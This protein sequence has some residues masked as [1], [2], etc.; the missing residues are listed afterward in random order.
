MGM[1]QNREKKTDEEMRSLR[2]REN[3]VTLGWTIEIDEERERERGLRKENKMNLIKKKKT[4][5]RR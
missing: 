2:L 1:N 4:C 5:R 3:S